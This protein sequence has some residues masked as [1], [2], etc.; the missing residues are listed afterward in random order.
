ML[1]KILFLDHPHPI[2]PERLQAAGYQ[3]HFNTTDNKSQIEYQ[4]A[5]YNGI[6]LRS[7]ISIDKKL[8][9]KAIN[10]QFI[11][12]EGVGVEH[13]DVEYAQSKG[14]H[15]I[16][17]P[18]GSRD[19]VGE[20]ALGMLLSLFNNLA[21]ADQ[22]VRNGEWIREANRGYEVKDKTVGI[23][24]YG[25]MGRSFAKKISGL[26]ANVIVYDKYKTNYGDAYA[27]AVDLPELFEKS[28]IISLHIYYIPENYHFV[29]DAF[30]NNF[31]KDIYIINTARGL[32]LNTADLVKNLKS[33]KVKGAALDVL[34]YEETSFNKMRFEEM[35]PPFHYLI[36]AKNVLLSPHIAGWTFES[37]KRH[38]EV[39][40]DKILNSF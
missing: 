25:N 3:C 10:L 4:I 12:R 7:R 22:Q 11:G 24:G 19:A 1:G 14:I 30:I 33:G 29:N 16:N 17:T 8:I 27:K 6:I 21:K 32:V 31:K 20:Q 36:K 2:L 39:L 38:S 26:E 40:A 35:P 9:D 37:K 23:I 13:I 34:E 28:D 5:D 18:E 15:I